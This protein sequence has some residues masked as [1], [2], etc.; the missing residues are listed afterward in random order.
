MVR[1][2]PWCTNQAVWWKSD[3]FCSTF[4][5]YPVTPGYPRFKGHQEY[6]LM[7]TGRV[8]GLL[9]ALGCWH[10]AH[11][12]RWPCPI[13]LAIGLRW[14]GLVVFM[15]IYVG[16]LFVFCSNLGLPDHDLQIF[17]LLYSTNAVGLSEMI[18]AGI[19]LTESLLW[20]SLSVNVYLLPFFARFVALFAQQRLV[21]MLAAKTFCSVPILLC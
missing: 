19:C 11:R 14:V 4:V 7:N 10:Q 17:V 3:I 9:P 6:E 21:R 5:G 16:S 15:L 8:S 12:P 18:L 1:Q 20:T 2:G 13:Q